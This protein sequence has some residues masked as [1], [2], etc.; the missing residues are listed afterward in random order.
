VTLKNGSGRHFAEPSNYVGTSMAAAHVSGLAAMVL[1]S[2]TIDPKAKKKGKVAAVTQRLRQT[3]RDLGLPP[4][5][6]G[7]GLVDAARAT[8]TE[9]PE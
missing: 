4:T 6:Q 3:A 5:R 8:A 7:A 9:P 1:A 2:A